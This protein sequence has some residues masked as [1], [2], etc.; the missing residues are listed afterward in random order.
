MQ[1]QFY[2]ASKTVTG[3][4][5][6][7]TVKNKKIL[8]D[9]GLFQGHKNLRLRNW[10]K[11]PFEPRDLDAIILTH[12][13][14]DHSGF[15]PVMTKLGFGGSVFCSPGTAELLRILLLDSAKIQEE[16]AAYANRKG[17]SKH[18]PALPLYTSDDVERCLSKVKIVD[19]RKETEIFDDIYIRLTPVGHIIG[20]ACV[21]IYGDGKTI[22]F[23]GDV[24]RFGDDVMNDPE[25]IPHC[26]YLVLESTYGDRVHRDT[27]PEALLSQHINDIFKKGGEVIIPAFAVGRTQKVIYHIINIMKDGRIP[28]VPVYMDSPM[29]I[30]ASEIFC[31]FHGEHKLSKSSC[32]NIFEKAII[33]RSQQ[34]SMNI[35]TV[36]GP[37]IVI[38]SS[39]MAT[40]GRV[41]HHLKRALPDS[42]SGV[43]FSGYQAGATR[44]A[45][46]VAGENTVKIHG[47][48]VPVNAKIVNIDTM[49][50]HGDAND[51]MYWVESLDKKP[52]KIFLNHGEEH[53]LASFQKKCQQKFP[54]TEILI[55]EEG[56]I[57]NL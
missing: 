32:H 54:D 40:G 31:K 1:L 4:K 37:K 55:A 50:A 22:T 42:S 27:D 34:E 3:S 28:R 24:G 6:L 25:D 5:S 10:E 8:I 29:G 53:A 51:L 49:S 23:S 9:C 15:L 35:A 39:G 17:F 46:L 44:G 21:T 57:I 26:D 48:Q 19:F 7:L 41:L 14:L 43:L 52:K 13:H 33:A 20:S 56:S 16:D 11:P 18:K 38:S 30:N 2:G 12:A 45:R 36:P 47:E